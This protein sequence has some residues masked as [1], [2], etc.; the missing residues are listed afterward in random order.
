VPGWTTI[1]WELNGISCSKTAGCT[2]VGDY[3]WAPTGI[4]FGQGESLML[5]E[6]LAP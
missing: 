6:Q 3:E 2:A 1:G 4:A 5:V